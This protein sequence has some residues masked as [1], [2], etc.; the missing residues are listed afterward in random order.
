MH[1][2]AHAP[3]LHAAAHTGEAAHADG[4][5]EHLFA[6]HDEDSC[7]LIDSLS[8]GGAA[9]PQA[10]CAPLVPAPYLLPLW[11]GQALARWAALFDARGPPA[12]VR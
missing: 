12:P 5:L 6:G 2:V 11:A 10:A 7:R 4:W 9:A 1:R 3:Q 8:Q